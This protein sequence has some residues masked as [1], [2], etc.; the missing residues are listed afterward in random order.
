MGDGI[1]TGFGVP[2]YGKYGDLK[3]KFAQ[4]PSGPKSAEADDKKISLW[5]N[6]TDF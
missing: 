2:S 6:L 3:G 4:G 1:R 5:W